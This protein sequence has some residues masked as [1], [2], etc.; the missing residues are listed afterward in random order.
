M[1]LTSLVSASDIFG[2]NKWHYFTGKSTLMYLLSA[3]FPFY[4]YKKMA[5]SSAVVLPSPLITPDLS[6]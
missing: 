1:A 2:G 4:S 5:E 3:V 6:W